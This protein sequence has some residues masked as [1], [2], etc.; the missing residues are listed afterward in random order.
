[1]DELLKKNRLKSCDDDPKDF[2]CK[3]FERAMAQMECA[4]TNIGGIL[5]SMVYQIE[6]DNGNAKGG[7]QP[8]GN[9]N[10]FEELSSATCCVVFYV[11]FKKPVAPSSVDPRTV[12]LLFVQVLLSCG[13]PKSLQLPLHTRSLTRHT[14]MCPVQ[15]QRSTQHPM[16]PMSSWPCPT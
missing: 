8:A 11:F 6:A 12:P 15:L 1:M 16:P 13:C 9:V 5:A 10:G 4:D 2:N 7:A 3:S 14:R